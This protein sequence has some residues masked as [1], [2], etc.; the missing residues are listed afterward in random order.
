MSPFANLVLLNSFHTHSDIHTTASKNGSYSSR[1]MTE[2]MARDY[3]HEL[4]D[5]M[6]TYRK[7]V[8]RSKKMAERVE[9]TSASSSSSRATIPPNTLLTQLNKYPALILNAD[10]QVCCLGKSK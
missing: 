9:N 8:A 5:D 2:S 3:A 4:Y 10:Y 6:V 1:T 7:T